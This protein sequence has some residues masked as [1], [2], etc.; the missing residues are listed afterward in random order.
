MV[1][2]R[3]GIY[4]T[5]EQLANTMIDLEVAVPDGILCLFSAWNIHGLTT[6]LPQAYHV[7]IKKGKKIRLLEYPPIALHFLAESI[8]EL[9][10]EE[11][12]V[13]NYEIK[14]YNVELSVCDAI[15]F[16]NKIGI[17]VCSK[18]VNNYLALPNRD[19]TLLMDNAN[20]LR[21]AKTLEKYLEIKL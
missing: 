15:K 12:V 21:I 6:S 14:V 11:K 20:K 18:V 3:R 5:L 19:L 9:G 7:A 13:S 16:R 8:L 1:C 17:D 4:A 10:A 2:I